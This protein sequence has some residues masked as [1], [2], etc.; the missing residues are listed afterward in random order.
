MLI[1]S[2]RARH[3]ISNA[4]NGAKLATRLRG[5]RRAPLSAG[6]LIACYRQRLALNARKAYCALV[7]AYTESF[8]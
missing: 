6:R 1:P 5:M 8:D 3:R 4:L 2:P 7:K